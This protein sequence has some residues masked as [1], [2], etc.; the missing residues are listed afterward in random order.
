MPLQRPNIQLTEKG[1]LFFF[2]ETVFLLA[3]VFGRGCY[4][5]L[6]L[7]HGHSDRFYS[8]HPTRKPQVTHLC[9][10][11]ARTQSRLQHKH[12]HSP[13]IKFPRLIHEAQM[14]SE[15]ALTYGNLCGTSLSSD[16]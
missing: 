15:E 7:K 4:N 13:V 5:D 3:F 10:C 2:L 1:K 11:A 8:N 12:F 6:I 14:T 16:C 9:L